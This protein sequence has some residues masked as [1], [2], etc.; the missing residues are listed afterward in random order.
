MSVDFPHFFTFFLGPKPS[1][2]AQDIPGAPPLLPPPPVR[3]PAP[4]PTLDPG[5]SWPMKNA[6]VQLD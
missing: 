3:P 2:T 1:P 6:G 5:E 4:V